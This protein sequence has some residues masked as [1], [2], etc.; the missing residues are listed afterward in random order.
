[1]K[2]NNDNNQVMQVDHTGNIVLGSGSADER[3]VIESESN[4][5]NIGFRSK[6]DDGFKLYSSFTWWY[7]R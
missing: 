4:E 1:M 5:A 6:N 3:L 7:Q 2:L